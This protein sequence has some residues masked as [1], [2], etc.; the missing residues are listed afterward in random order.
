MSGTGEAAAKAASANGVPAPPLAEQQ[1]PLTSMERLALHS[2]GL[3]FVP[4]SALRRRA[5][6]AASQSATSPSSAPKTAAASAAAPPAPPV[7]SSK[8]AAADAPQAAAAAT[9]AATNHVRQPF[10]A[11]IRGHRLGDVCGSYLVSALMQLPT[12]RRQEVLSSLEVGTGYGAE[13]QGALTCVYQ[14]SSCC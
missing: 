11:V 6:A 7:P 10:N 14:T 9:A 12:A 13:K 1:L 5:V 4:A 2:Q 3:T 8:A